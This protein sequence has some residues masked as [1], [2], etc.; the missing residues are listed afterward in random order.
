MAGDHPGDTMHTLAGDNKTDKQQHL[1]PA[2][3]SSCPKSVLKAT[4]R[5]FQHS[6]LVERAIQLIPSHSMASIFS[7][8]YCMVSFLGSYW[9]ESQLQVIAVVA[10][11]GFL[12]NTHDLQQLTPFEN[13]GELAV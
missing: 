8:P 6:A 4:C 10:I 2:L 7:N 11:A 5:S 9:F 3:S 1:H 12:I 13:Y